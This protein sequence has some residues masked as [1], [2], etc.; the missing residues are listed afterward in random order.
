LEELRLLDAP[1]TPNPF[2]FAEQITF[3]KEPLSEVT[4]KSIKCGTKGED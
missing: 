4:L 3:D 1:S 2:L